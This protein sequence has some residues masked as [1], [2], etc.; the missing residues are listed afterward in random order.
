MSPALA[1]ELG[2]ESFEDG[3]YILRLDGRSY[4]TRMGLRPGDKIVAIN[5]DE[6][7]STE[8][9]E[10][11]MSKRAAS[12]TISIKRGGKVMKRVVDR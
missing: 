9:L 6:I 5:N 7:D 4:A 12:W 11:V 10:R 8:T 1:D 3:V 2:L